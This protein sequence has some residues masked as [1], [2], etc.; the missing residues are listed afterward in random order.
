MAREFDAHNERGTSKYTAFRKN[1]APT[2]LGY[3]VRDGVAL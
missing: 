2:L 3:S 1:L